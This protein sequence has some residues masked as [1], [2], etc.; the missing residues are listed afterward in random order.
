MGSSSKWL[1]SIENEAV[2]DIFLRGENKKGWKEH[3][4][5]KQTNIVTLRKNFKSRGNVGN[6]QI[7]E[8]QTTAQKRFPCRNERNENDHCYQDFSHWIDCI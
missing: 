6:V 1:R 5:W 8:S 4:G 7:T 3:Q 2:C